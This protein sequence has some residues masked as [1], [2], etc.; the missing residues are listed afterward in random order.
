LNA[1]KS[2]TKTFVLTCGEGWW[3]ENGPFLPT[4]NDKCPKTVVSLPRG[5][6]YFISQ[7]VG[8]SWY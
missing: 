7:R 2:L 1:H 4:L 5:S 8:T 6:E 3:A